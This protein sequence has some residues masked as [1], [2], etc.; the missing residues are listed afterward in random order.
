MG[1]TADRIKKLVPFETQISAESMNMNTQWAPADSSRFVA[2]SG[3]GFRPAEATFSDTIRW[4]VEAGHLSPK[5]A[6]RLG[7][8]NASSVIERHGAP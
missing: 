2:R 6:G 7:V 8:P 4:M 1:A 5:K 3:L